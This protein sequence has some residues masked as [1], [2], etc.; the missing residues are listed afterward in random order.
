M[1]PMKTFMN[2]QYEIY[3]AVSRG[4]VVPVTTS[5][6]G[7]SYIATVE[8]ITSLSAGVSF[9]MI[10]HTTSTVKLPALN[11][12]GF[13]EKFIC[14]R[15]STTSGGF[16]ANGGLIDEWIEEGFPIKVTYN[17]TDWIADITVP[18]ARYLFS[19]VPIHSGGTGAE[20]AAQALNNLGIT[21]GKK[22]APTT[23]TP[24]TI[25]IQIN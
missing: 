24:N 11:V 9:V 7:A 17:G 2:G 5:G 19:A 13:G 14:P 8:G 21:W 6:N 16:I 4:R 22:E 15:I 18:D 3:D 23:G 1:E 25:Y 12:N 20:T 10:P